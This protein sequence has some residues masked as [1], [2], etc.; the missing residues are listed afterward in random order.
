MDD[1]LGRESARHFGLRY[2]RLIGVL[3]DAKHKGFI[4]SVKP[5]LDQLRDI[6]GFRLS[7]VLYTKVLRNQGEA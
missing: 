2:T 3:I 7:D 1:H 5:C 6:A 4:A